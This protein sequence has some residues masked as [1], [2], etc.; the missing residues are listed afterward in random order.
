MFTLTVENTTY[1]ANTLKELAN[2]I[3]N[4]AKHPIFFFVDELDEAE[5]DDDFGVGD[6]WE[7]YDGSI[8]L[9]S[10]GTPEYTPELL[11]KYA[12]WAHNTTAENVHI[13]EE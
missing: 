10:R 2:E 4:T 7:Y 9:A 5:Y 11:T 3:H 8:L 6:H 1:T 13:T 12:A